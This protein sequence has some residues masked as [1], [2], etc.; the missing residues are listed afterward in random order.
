LVPLFLDHA[1]GWREVGEN[2]VLRMYEG[3]RICGHGY[4]RW[5]EPATWHMPEQEQDRLAEWLASA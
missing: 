5:V 4:V 3:A 1:P 2:D